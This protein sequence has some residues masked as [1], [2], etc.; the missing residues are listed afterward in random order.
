MFSRANILTLPNILTL[1]RA[2]IAPFVAIAIATEHF[3]QALAL[4]VVGGLT[5]I[6]DGWLARLTKRDNQLGAYLDPIA[7]KLLILA[8]YAGLP[9]VGLMPFWLSF[10]IIGRD[11]LIVGGFALLQILQAPIR[12]LPTKISKIT[13]VFQIA[14]AFYLLFPMVVT[15]SPIPQLVHALFITT[16]LLTIASAVVYIMIGW[17]AFSN[18]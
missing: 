5:D 3:V 16:V 4:L 10:L 7:D 15:I 14:T 18:R 2:L 13:T 8:C 6:F 11:V 12:V 9:F 17:R 1:I